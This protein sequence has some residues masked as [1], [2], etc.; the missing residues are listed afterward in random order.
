MLYFIAV[1]LHMISNLFNSTCL[2]YS[3]PSNSR[4]TRLALVNEV[5]LG[6][7]K[8][9]D[10]FVQSL[11][12]PPDG[13]DSAHGVRNQEGTTSKFKD[14]EFVIYNTAQQRIRFENIVL[15]LLRFTERLKTK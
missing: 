12:K 13:Y 1:N 9:F 15:I 14:D 11:V 10:E 2:K 4:G 5:A 8:D 3:K 7:C 6:K